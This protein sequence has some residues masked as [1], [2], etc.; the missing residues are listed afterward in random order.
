MFQPNNTVLALDFGDVRVGVALTSI[1]ARLPSP[2]VT[3]PNSPAL[4][5]DIGD[6]IKT[7]GVVAIVIGHPKNR[8][9]EATDQTRKVEAF[10]ARIKEKLA[11]P[12]YLVDEAETSIQAENRLMERGKAFTKE[13]VDALAASF[14]LEEFFKEH[15][16][17]RY[18]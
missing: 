18:E 3:L 9:G 16:E 8:E 11:I 14:I 12:V 10:A 4:L 6:L 13:D 1:G 7:H 5:D 2:L 17:F 15:P